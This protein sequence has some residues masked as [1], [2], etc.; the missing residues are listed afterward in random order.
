M[1]LSHTSAS[2]TLLIL[3]L[4]TTA[5]APRAPVQQPLDDPTALG[6]LEALVSYDIQTGGLGAKKGT[7]ADVKQVASGF[8]ADHKA[9]LKKTQDEGKKLGIKAEKPKEAPLAAEHAA[10]MN[11][12]KSTNGDEFNR[13]WILNEVRY[14]TDAIRYLQDS[15]APAVKNPELKSFV[16]MSAV[17]AFQGH[18]AVA[19]KLA[20]KY[21]V[22]ASPGR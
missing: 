15:L 1:S 4:T 6:K 7:N 5:P 19:Q 18:L 22:S 3:G 16:Q 21:H 11:K 12:L 9:L 2:L 20:T 10:A 14:H 8:E 17:P 13:V